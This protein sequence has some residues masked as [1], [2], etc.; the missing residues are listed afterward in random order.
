VSFHGSEQI[1]T[2]HLDDLAYKGV[3]LKNYYVSPIC[4]PTR[5]ALMSGRHPIHT[6]WYKIVLVFLNYETTDVT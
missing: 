4:T 1:S 6:G 3:L 2:P 5:G